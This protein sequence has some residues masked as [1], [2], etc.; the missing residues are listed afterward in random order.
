MWKLVVLALL[1]GGTLFISTESEQPPNNLW[2][3]SEQALG[4]LRTTSE[5][6]PNDLRT[7]SERPLDN[8]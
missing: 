7:T 4:D 6:A 3:T 1:I 2:T 8:L 5:Q